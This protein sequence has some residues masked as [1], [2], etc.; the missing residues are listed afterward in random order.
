MNLSLQGN[1]FDHEMF[2]RFPNVKSIECAKI[3][4]DKLIPLLPSFT[5]LHSLT[6]YGSA[7]IVE[8]EVCIDIHTVI[9]EGCEMGSIR[10]LGK[11]RVVRLISCRG[12]V[13]DVSPLA[14][15]PLVSIIDCRFKM[16]NY[17]SLQNVP[18]LKVDRANGKYPYFSHLEFSP[19]FSH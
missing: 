13:L 15:V 1:S 6:F 19:I 3:P 14:T 11:N 16:M 2:A 10:G 12:D 4:F 5:N 9:F 17:E 18:R 8:I 7:S